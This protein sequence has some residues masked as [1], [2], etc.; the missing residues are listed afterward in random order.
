VFDSDSDGYS[1]GPDPLDAFAPQRLVARTPGLRNTR[2][3]SGRR[4]D[5]IH[6]PVLESIST[7]SPAQRETTR[8]QPRYLP[9]DES[10]GFTFNAIQPQQPD[11]TYGGMYGF[12]ASSEIHSGRGPRDSQTTLQSHGGPSRE[13][14]RSIQSA[15]AAIRRTLDSPSR[16]DTTAS[17]SQNIGG[18]V[19]Q[20][21]VMSQGASLVT[22]PRLTLN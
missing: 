18:D 8:S 2:E 1:S 15:D 5:L 3:G 19:F 21:S 4:D 20:S 11:W 17:S 16:T 22:T 9:G 10:E 6:I 7:S 12:T 13:R 14:R